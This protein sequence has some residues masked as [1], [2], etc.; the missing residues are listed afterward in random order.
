MVV[1]DA[2]VGAGPL[3]IH[4]GGGPTGLWDGGNGLGKPRGIP[5][6]PG[7]TPN[8]LGGTGGGNGG[9]LGPM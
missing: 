3:A 6:I 7:G 2:E 5:I 1:F 4:G 9:I 8:G